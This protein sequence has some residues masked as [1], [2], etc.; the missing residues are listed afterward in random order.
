LGVLARFE[1]EPAFMNKPVVKVLAVVALGAALWWHAVVLAPFVLSLALAYVLQPTMEAL[2]RR[3]WPRSLAASAC[4]LSAFLLALFLVLLLVPIVLELGPQLQQ[5]VPVLASDAWHAL[6][7]L[8]S[9]V[10]VRVPAELADLRPVLIKLF[11]THASGWSVALLQS[12]RVGGNLLLTVVGLSVLVPVLSFYWLLDW[13]RLVD[14]LRSLVP[15]R[16]RVAVDD[17]VVEAD[18]VMGHYLRGQIFVMLVLAVFYSLGLWLFGF[19]LAWPIGVFTGLAVFIPYVGFGL[20]LMLAVLSGV[21][22]FTA[23]GEQ[24]WWPLMAVG[25]VYGIGQLLETI[26]LTPRLVGERIGLH[27]AGV[28]FALMLFAHWM[29]FVGVLM[30]LPVSALVMVV[31]RRTI[32]GYRQSPLFLDQA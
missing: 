13:Q 25:V 17:F 18:D 28:I 16:W 2:V 10:G 22:Q 7:P 14:G 12:A 32:R 19:D 6:V 30:A 15:A 29:G 8:L 26:V 20:G 24:L 1:Q 27:P 9:Q 3:R 4:V 5:Q 11:Q 21:L 23:Q 31:L